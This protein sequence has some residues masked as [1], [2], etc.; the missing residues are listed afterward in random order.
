MFFVINSANW[1]VSPDSPTA[2]ITSLSDNWYD[3]LWSEN[4]NKYMRKHWFIIYLLLFNTFWEKTNNALCNFI[5]LTYREMCYLRN[6]PANI[7]NSSYILTIFHNKN[8]TSI[9]SV[10]GHHQKVIHAKAYRALHGLNIWSKF[11]LRDKMT[12]IFYIQHGILFRLQDTL[13]VFPNSQT[14]RDG[15][16]TYFVLILWCHELSRF[17]IYIFKGSCMRISSILTRFSI[18]SMDLV[19]S[20]SISY[21]V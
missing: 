15:L 16:R 3:F 8:T 13:L 21:N 11:V 9:C 6:N 17:D 5:V 4:W 18:K 1:L 7:F 20:N 12:C 2:V 19:L 14:D 10:C